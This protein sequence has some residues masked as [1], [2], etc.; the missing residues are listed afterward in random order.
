MNSVY[1]LAIY[2]KLWN[3]TYRA[4]KSVRVHKFVDNSSLMLWI[5]IETW[6]GR[7]FVGAHKY[8]K[9]RTIT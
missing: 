3:V 5:L 4:S 6:E 7:A 9:W 1:Q 2:L 8:K